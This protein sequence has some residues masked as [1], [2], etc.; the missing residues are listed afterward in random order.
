MPTPQMPF[1]TPLTGDPNDVAHALEAGS[2]EWGRGDRRE[3]VRWV[4]RAADAAEAAGDDR[5][6]VG[7]ARVAADLMSSLAPES[8]SPVPRD[9]GAA[10]APFDDFNDQTIVDSPAIQAARTMH[11][12]VTITGVTGVTI[13]ERRPSKPPPPPRP[14]LVGVPKPSI[15]AS[16]PV[17]PSARPS[18]SVS[19][20]TPV[21]ASAKPAIPR[22]ALRVSVARGKD[23][24]RGLVVNV[25]DEGAV[26]P[27]GTSEALLVL[28]DPNSALARDAG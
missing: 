5:R 20:S 4:H 17:P 15:S 1:P 24:E 27:P 19:A 9:E 12:S 6:A 25:L 22:T 8:S 2:A 14:G 10:L 21:P 23:G 28:L 13:S 18:V 3:A 7:L 26:A 16:T 11:S